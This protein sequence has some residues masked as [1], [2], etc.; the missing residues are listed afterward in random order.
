MEEM[1]V[2]SPDLVRI[3][4]SE[5]SWIVE[6]DPDAAKVIDRMLAG[7][8]ISSQIFESGRQLIEALSIDSHLP[9]VICLDLT[10][11]DMNG[12]DL[13]PSL[14]RRVPEIP[15]VVITSNTTKET[16]SKA[17]ELG[18]YDY[19]AKNSDRNKF[20]TTFKRAT[21]YRKLCRELADVK[22]N[23]CDQFGMVGISPALR[24]TVAKV[25]ELGPIDVN[26]LIYGETGTG[27][28]LAARGLHNCSNRSRGPLVTLN[29]AVLPPNLLESELFG[30]EKG[31]FTGAD[32]RHIGAFERADKGTLFLDEIGELD[33]GL[34][35]KLLRAIEQRS[36]F[37]VGGSKEISSNFRLVTATNRDLY[38]EA[39]SG[40]FRKDL[41]YRL[42]VTDINLQPLR[43]RLDD[44]P[45]LTE[46]FLNHFSAQLG[47]SAV[48]APET[49]DMLCRY[50]WPGNVRE[51]QN[52]IQYALIQ[53][54][55]Q[56]ITPENLPGRIKGYCRSDAGSA[57]VV[58]NP[59]ELCDANR[60]QIR[61]LGEQERDSVLGSLRAASG[62]ISEAAV[63]LGVSRATF[64]RMMKRHGIS[65]RGRF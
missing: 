42:S 17:V 63:M 7:L 59:T 40:R 47:K 28:E 22:D 3:A 13:L 49:A 53:C 43:G 23:L 55:G 57:L 32:K 26:V 19:L 37:R 45:L 56:L 50:N 51:L 12:L 18:V 4:T 38:D 9:D 36:F 41:Y 65:S 2:K 30:H 52:V 54:T 35:A 58:R 62:N 5:C 16:I 27:K 39:N 44:V 64:Y 29:C 10:L 8:G 14:K 31:A 46:Y 33:F 34:Q 6:D 24:S 15:V 60:V 11:P 21:E 20:V 48:I 25:R 1:L 61:P